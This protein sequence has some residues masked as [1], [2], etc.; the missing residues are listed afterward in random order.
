MKLSVIRLVAYLSLS[1]LPLYGLYAQSGIEGKVIDEFGNPVQNVEIKVGDKVAGQTNDAGR[2]SV[3]VNNGD[4]LEFSCMGYLSKSF[5]WTGKDWPVVIM[6]KDFFK[7]ASSIAYGIR[8]NHSQT[9]AI[10]T[11]SGDEL[12][13]FPTQVL[14]TSLQGKLPGLT[15]L[16]N[17][18]EPGENYPMMLIRGKSTYQDNSYLVFVDGFESVMDPLIAEEIESIS[19]LKDAAALAPFGMRGANG[20]IWLTTKKGQ[21][22]PMQ[23]NLESR[24]GLSQPVRIPGFMDAYNYASLYNEAYSNDAGTWSPVYSAGE[25]EKFRSG[26]D[27]VF[28]PNVDWYGEN[29]KN[30]VP[31]TEN[32]ISARGGNQIARYYVM[33]GYRFADKLYNEREST[34]NPSL[35]NTGQSGRYNFR[36]NLDLTLNE[37]F[38]SSMRIGGSLLD[39]TEPA[40]NNMFSLLEKY[41]PNIYPVKN[42]DESW[43]GSA[44]YPDNLVAGIQEMGARSTHQRWL[45]AGISL[46]E[47]LDQ[48]VPG[49]SYSQEIDLSSWYTN[50]YNQLKTVATFQPSLSDSGI[51]YIQ[52][53]QETPFNISDGGRRQWNRVNLALSGYYNRTFGNTLMDAM[54]TY[55]QDKFNNGETI[56]FVHTGLSGWL[57]FNINGTYFATVTMAYNGSQNYAEGKRFGFF[58]AFSAGWMLSNSSILQNV[59]WIDV[60]KIRGSA[61]MLGYDGTDRY[62]YVTYFPRGDKYIFGATGIEDQSTYREARLGNPDITWEKSM[63]YNIGLESGFF[64]NRLNLTLD[65][66]FEN[67]T[68]I[69]SQRSLILPAVLGVELPLEN[70][71]AVS[72][73]GLELDAMFS[74]HAGP[75][76]YYAG[77]ILSMARNNIENLDELYAEDYLYRTGNPIGQPFGLEA[78]GLFQNWDDINDPATPVHTFTPV[79]P[80]DIRYA[81]QN[82]DGLITDDDQIPID[83]TY[84]PELTYSFTLG[85]KYKGFDLEVFLTGA[86]NRS[87]IYSGNAFY[88]FQN[89]TQVPQIASGRWAYYPGQGIDTRATADYPRLSTVYNDNNYRASTFWTHN[90]SY[91]RL[92][93]VELGYSLPMKLSGN[94]L[95]KNIRIYISGINLLTLDKLEDY[96]AEVMTGYPL[97]RSYHIGFKMNL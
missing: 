64:S 36:S 4:I 3:E 10:S 82:G 49:L 32:N 17:S 73:S 6:K 66:F 86:A 21:V 63:K 62:G 76:T 75:L 93:Q 96:D 18:G 46:R 2:F 27:P 53:G 57:N 80:G 67:R 15:V 38:S 39:N 44:I 41:P 69:L 7:K 90:G 94:P 22:S 71:G 43:G 19:V 52:W 58:P 79:Q 65:Y 30:A 5:E 31:Y 95:V 29:L 26:S 9:A 85:G 48:F 60:L 68:D 89:N 72:N 56:P 92:R 84:Y 91:L 1:F 20:V 47:D 16:E 87:V 23:V 54:I 12:S 42:T 28:Y 35:K 81:D 97:M 11:V 13:G 88:A 8:N 34:E 24:V 50:N 45:Q 59:T 51:Q 25:L 83:F 70:I 61:G 74:D 55:R 78:L 37:V 33:L 77:G 14:N 40:M